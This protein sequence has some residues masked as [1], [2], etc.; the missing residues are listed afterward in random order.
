M[1]DKGEKISLKERKMMW[2]IHREDRKK[3][4][5]KF[6]K[7]KSLQVMICVLVVLM[8]V[9]FCQNSGMISQMNKYLHE[10]SGQV[11]DIYDDTKVIKAYK[12]QNTEGLSSEETFLYEKLNEIIGEN[13]KP[14]MSDYEKEKAIYEWQ[15]GWTHLASDSLNPIDSSADNYTPYGV[16]KSHAAICVGNATTFKLFMDALDIPCMII[17]STENGEHAWDIVQ[18]DDEWYHV[19]LTFDNGN[20]GRAGYTYFNVPDSV[21]DDGNWPW[22][23]SKIPAC[24]GYKY[25]YMYMNS[26]ELEN[27]YDIPEKLKAAIVNNDGIFSFTLKDKSDF[28][29]NVASYISDNMIM[30][31]GSCYFDKAFPI[32]DKVVY[33]YTIYNWDESDMGIIPQEIIDKLMPIFDRVNQMGNT[34]GMIVSDPLIGNGIEE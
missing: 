31:N 17:H 21:K 13:I 26:E 22:D 34:P 6:F 27:I 28:S 18:L 12:A 24:N 20:A 25:C 2:K 3:A 32:G 5:K 23:H 33:R 14:S 29:S 10:A 4:V 30:D 11:H 9:M 19:D 16:L 7:G 8:A 1:V 15:Y